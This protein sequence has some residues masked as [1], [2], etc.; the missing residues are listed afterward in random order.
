M[1]FIR[2]LLDD[3]KMLPVDFIM[4]CMI[5]KI[6]VLLKITRFSK[7]FLQ[8]NRLLTFPSQHIIRENPRPKKKA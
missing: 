1:K 6:S 2:K 5:H 8:Y 4:I 7:H 3:I